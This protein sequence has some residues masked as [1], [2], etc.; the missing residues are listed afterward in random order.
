MPVSMI[1][2]ATARTVARA[3]AALF[4]AV[5][6]IVWPASASCA[7]TLADYPHT[8]VALDDTVTVTWNEDVT[9]NLAY[10]RAPGSY[11]STTSATGVR[12]LSFIPFEE[13]MA[14]GIWYCVLDDVSSSDISEEFR[15]IV[16]SPV[17]LQDSIQ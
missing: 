10:G 1:G 8:L 17:L 13:Y 2:R 7:I 9:C 6:V 3:T 12:S 14:P 5:I 11:I 15:L 4:V 16:E